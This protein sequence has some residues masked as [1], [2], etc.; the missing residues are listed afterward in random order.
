VAAGRLLGALFLLLGAGSAG[1]QQ[2]FQIWYTYNH[3][4]LLTDRWGYTFDVNHRTRDILPAEAALTAARVGGIYALTPRLRITAGYA[5]FGTYVPDI[6]RIL[7]HEHRLYQQAQW[8]FRP[9]G[10]LL[11][12]RIRTEQRW[13]ELL[14]DPSDSADPVT[15]T[16]FNFRA[17]YMLQVSGP[18]TRPDSTGASLL[19]WQ[20]TNEIFFQTSEFERLFDQNRTLAGVVW[21][22]TGSLDLATLYQVIVQRRPE[23]NATQNIHSVRLTLF[24]TLDFRPGR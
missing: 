21:R 22:L 10:L 15:R 4:G 19:R 11:S 1:A 8:T 6:E 2:P 18:L 16:I 13:R 14:V 3:V 23:F 9:S 7:L 20:A 17:R 5:W 12:H 24:H